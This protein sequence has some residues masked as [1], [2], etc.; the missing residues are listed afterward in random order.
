M[1]RLALS[2]YFKWYQNTGSVDTKQDLL[3]ILSAALTS[4]ETTN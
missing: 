4:D 1:K 3:L 2:L